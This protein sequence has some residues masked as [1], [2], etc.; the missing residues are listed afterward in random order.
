MSTPPHEKPTAG[1][2]AGTA[3]RPARSGGRATLA[4][5]ASP[6]VRLD[7]DG[8]IDADLPCPRCGYLLRGRKPGT[9]CPECGREIDVEAQADP[10]AAGPPA[11]RGAVLGG[12]RRLSVGMALLPLGVYPG[13]AV[14]TA[15]V[16]SLTTKPPGPPEPWLQRNG[17]LFAR[18]FTALGLP[19]MVAAVA[20]SAWTLASRR[21][22]GGSWTLQ[23]TALCGTHALF[24]IGLMFAWRHLYDLAARADA[25]AAAL[26]LRK[27]WRGYFRALVAVAAIGLAV[28]AADRLDL[29]FR[30]GPRWRGLVAPA[31]ALLL[32]ALA[33]GL[34]A[35]TFARARAF[36]AALEAALA[37]PRTA[38]PRG[39][40][41]PR[42]AG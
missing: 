17:R 20:W 16:W 4:F 40:Q 30:I 21:G 38:G 12:A 25:P 39:L 14:A 19:A 13:L 5:P 27:L 6:P 28:N 22:V 23:D 35:W 42:S 32:L 8:R 10:L 37:A 2:A 29:L 18:W 41:P 9:A 31:T 7:G 33:V 24:F 34:W 36:R 15:G 1:P 3:P 11:F 26:S